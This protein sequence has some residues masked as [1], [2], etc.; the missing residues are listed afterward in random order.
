[1][2]LTDS[3]TYRPR[4]GFDVFPV[5]SCAH[6]HVVCFD[7]QYPSVGHGVVDDAF[8]IAAE[9]EGSEINDIYA[10]V[11]APIQGTWYIMRKKVETLITD[12]LQTLIRGARKFDVSASTMA[13]LVEIKRRERRETTKQDEA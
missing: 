2:S 9:L 1:V 13:Q 6:F 10:G 4:F 12:H 5:K 3:R 11:I 8:L 7:R